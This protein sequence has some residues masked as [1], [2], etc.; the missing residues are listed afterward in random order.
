MGTEVERKFL[1][2]PSKLPVPLASER[3]TLLTQG[4]LANDPWIRIRLIGDTK[5]RLTIK[6][7]GNVTRP[8][9]EYDIPRE[10]AEELLKMCPDQITKVRHEIIFEGRKWEVDQ[11]FGPLSG[12]WLAE[13]ELKE[14][15]EVFTCPPWAVKEVS[16]L[17]E[18]SNAQLVVNGL[19]EDYR[20]KR[21]SPER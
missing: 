9:F 10:N 18:Y 13:I 21:E 4:Y 15:E 17:P 7:N 16:E 6:G 12:F 20:L 1:V 11:F 19:P 2:D 5:A 14:E 8:E 3:S